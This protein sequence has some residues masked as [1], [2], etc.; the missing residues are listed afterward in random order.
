MLSCKADTL[1]TARG[2]EHAFRTHS[3]PGSPAARV[4]EAVEEFKGHDVVF[5][6]VGSTRAQ[7]GSAKAFHKIDF[8]VV[9]D[10]AKAAKE[11]GV[12]HFRCVRCG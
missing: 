10:S 8:G 5:C 1:R 12:P 6:T 4:A 2:G 11:A 3:I 9:D 7:A